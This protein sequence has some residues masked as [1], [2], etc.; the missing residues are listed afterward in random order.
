MLRG[1]EIIGSL[2]KNIIIHPFN[3]NQLRGTTYNLRVGK[4]VW[5]HATSSLDYS[6]QSKSLPLEGIPTPTGRRFDIPPG[7]L[8]SIMTE[9]VVWVDNTVAGLFH[10]KVD[11]VTKGF[12]HISTTLDPGWI[13]PLL[14][15]MC[16]YSSRTLLLWQGETFVKLSFHK[17]SRPTQRKHNNPPGRGDRLGQEGFLLP[18]GHENFLD[19]QVNCIP[20]VLKEAF[21]AS[22]AWQKLHKNRA[23]ASGRARGWMVFVLATLAFVISVTAPLWFE[24]VFGIK[25]Q[26]EALSGIFASMLV[27]Y[28]FFLQALREP[29][30]RSGSG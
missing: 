13:G 3:E 14:I 15:T 10:S 4:Y 5:L 2:G 6:T 22:D 30:W 16:N 18:S 27:T 9:E 17:L 8:V 1:E 25:P 29:P 21:E 26:D 19:D 23:S 28:H 24:R 7:A 12:S 20:S 11:M